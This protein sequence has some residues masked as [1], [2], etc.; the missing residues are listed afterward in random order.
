MLTMLHD[1]LMAATFG[2]ALVIFLFGL[3]DLVIDVAALAR[4]LYRALVI[5]RR[6]RPLHEDDLRR[7][8]EQWIAVMIPAW[9]EAAV[10]GRMLETTATSFDYAHYRLFVGCYANDPETSERVAEAAAR[11]PQVVPVTL[12]HDGPTSKADCLNGIVD[13]IRDYEAREKI[14]FA[15]FV[16][17]DA[18]DVVHPLELRLFNFLIPRKDMVQLPVIPLERPLHHFTAGHY[19]DEFAELHG[20]DLLVR[21]MLFGHVP[22]AGVGCAFSRRAVELMAR[23][24]DGR[25]FN[26]ASL[27]EDY[28]FALR[29]KYL[30]L[31]QIFVRFAVTRSGPRHHRDRVATRE[32]FPDRFGA[33]C[34]QKARWLLGIVFQSM[35]AHGWRGPWPLKYALYRD[36]KG[37]LTAFLGILANMLALGWAVLWLARLATAADPA[38]FAPF[39]T[40]LTF[41]LAA[42]AF[43]LVNRSLQRAAAVLAVYGPAQALMSV[44]RQV[45]GNVINCAAGIR[46]LVLFCRHLVTGHPLAWD[47]T[48]HA[49]PTVE[50]LRPFHERLGQR[51]LGKGLVD[52][53]ALRRA[54]RRQRQTNEP[55]GLI[56]GIEETQLYAALAEQ[57]GLE[58]R[59]DLAGSEP[60]PLREELAL[61]HDVLPLVVDGGWEIAAARPLGPGERAIIAAACPEPPR[62]TIA[63][64]RV[65][66]AGRAR[67]RARAP[68]AVMLLAFIMLC[69]GVQPAQAATAY[70]HAAM[71]FA[72]YDAGD[73]AAAAE[74]FEHA[75]A[76][77][78]DLVIVAAQL[79][80]AYRKLGRNDDAARAFRQAMAEAV[81]MDADDRHR[82]RREVQI[83]EN[84]LDFSLYHVHR[85]AAIPDHQ[86]SLA[87]P[88]L[89]QSQSGAELAWIP[90]GIGFRDGRVLRLGGRLLWGYDGTS[91]DPRGESVQAGLG[92]SYKPLADHNL[93]IGAERLIGIGADA[94][95]DWMLRA[96]YSWVRG[97][98]PDFARKRWTYLTFYGEAA[99]IDPADPDLLLA[100]E[101]RGGR[102]FRLTGDGYGPALTLTPHLVLAAS[103]QKD[104]FAATELLEAGPGMSLKLH[105]AD[106]PASAHGGSMDIVLQYRAKLAGNSAGGSGLMLTLVFLR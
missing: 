29:L 83:L 38:I 64:P 54:L 86:L 49:F 33:A 105:F 25:P 39:P 16:L 62:W 22:S 98:G 81:E 69:L 72:A 104:S 76:T 1:G 24:R 103:R 12:P 52:R 74:A 4:R 100:A 93:V 26:P 11:F 37:L 75:L 79:G 28:D 106:T 67:A 10:I 42:N 6:H 5:F 55:L 94:R 7:N 3:D 36:R 44:P 23:R 89:T 99:V 40:A 80:Y 20:K 84:R 82:L 19:M 61:H 101:V 15:M 51:L 91:L 60:A 73:Y 48:A 102:S 78:P 50:Q 14:T 47:K 46:A 21:E 58:F 27:T 97:Y 34:R 31:S 77:R 66:R 13:G 90:P 35:R 18:E 45:W 71:G 95:D 30:G 8:P 41:L 43:L 59:G 32:F 87:G 53:R 65:I 70:D 68:V 17:H 56:L 9:R 63:P 88:T 92:L 85:E 2:V 96:G 57:W